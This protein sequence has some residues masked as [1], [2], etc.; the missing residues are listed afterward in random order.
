MPDTEWITRQ[1]FE[2]LSRRYDTPA[3]QAARKAAERRRLKQAAQLAGFASIVQLANAL[4]AGTHVVVA[5]VPE[6]QP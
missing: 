3:K 2:E 5:R 6:Q 1:R 4:L